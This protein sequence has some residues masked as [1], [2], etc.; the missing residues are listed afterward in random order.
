[1]WYFVANILENCFL[2]EMQDLN[3]RPLGPKPSA[4]PDYANLRIILKGQRVDIED[5]VLRTIHL[6]YNISDTPL[7]SSNVSTFSR[8]PLIITNCFLRRMQDSNL[9]IPCE[10]GGFQDRSCTN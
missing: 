2:S 5:F 8:V 9:H 7:H 10:N 3:L 1:M 6:I 4:I